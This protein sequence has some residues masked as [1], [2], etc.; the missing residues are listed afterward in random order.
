MAEGQMTAEYSIN[1]ATEDKILNA[2]I[3]KTK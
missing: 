3:P 1:E 2:A